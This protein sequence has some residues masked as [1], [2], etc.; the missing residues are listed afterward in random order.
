MAIMVISV[1]IPMTSCQPST[2]EAEGLDD[3]SL[4]DEAVDP[5][6][7]ERRRIAESGRQLLDPSAGGA[8]APGT[9]EQL[10]DAIDI[11][12]NYIVGISAQGPAPSMHVLNGWGII[13]PLRG[14]SFTVLST[15]VVNTFPEPGTDMAPG[16]VNGDSASLELELNIP[17]G[18]RRLSFYY[19]FLSSESPEFIGAGFN[20]TFTATLTEP[21]GT[22]HQLATASVDASEFHDA[23]ESNSRDTYFDIKSANTDGVNYLFNQTG[24]YD[25]GV[26]GFQRVDF[27]LPTTGNVTLHFEIHDE[28]DGILDSAVILDDLRLHAME[29]LSLNPI[30]DNAEPELINADGSLSDDSDELIAASHPVRGAAADGVTQVLL[31]TRVPGPGSM[32]YSLVDAVAPYNGENGGVSALNGDPG[33][34]AIVD[35][36]FDAA[37]GEHWAFAAYTVP[38]DF[39]RS[40]HEEDEGARRRNIEI[41]AQFIPDGATAP[42]IEDTQNLIIV[43]PPVILVGGVWTPT[44]PWYSYF[45]DE[46]R[47]DFYH[48]SDYNVDVNGDAIDDPYDSLAHITDYAGT[49][50]NATIQK[51]LLD[52][53]E[54]SIAASQ[55][56]IIAHGSGGLLVR[57]HMSQ[58]SYFENSHN[59][60]QGSIHKLIT[61]NTPHLGS[62]FANHVIRTRTTYDAIYP[63]KGIPADGGVFNELQEGSTFLDTMASVPTPSHAIVGTD[64]VGETRLPVNGLNQLTDYSGGIPWYSHIALNPPPPALPFA[65]LADLNLMLD[66]MFP[67]GQ[68][69]DLF[70]TIDSQSGGL[71]GTARTIVDSSYDAADGTTDSRGIHY[72]APGGANS[73]AAPNETKLDYETIFAQRLND[74]VNGDTFDQLPT[75]ASVLPVTETIPA[76]PGLP[77]ALAFVP[78]GLTI[79][80]PANNTPVEPG[81]EIEVIVEIGEGVVLE[82][83]FLFSEFGSAYMGQPVSPAAI[84]LPIREDAAGEINVRAVGFDAN[85][86]VYGSPGLDLGAVPMAPLDSLRLFPRTPYLFGEGSTLSATV[87][88]VYDDGVHRDVT[89][90]VTGTEYSSSNTSI[91]TVSPDGQVTATGPGK[92]TL[93]ARNGGVQDSVTVDVR[94]GMLAGFEMTTDWGLGYCASVRVTNNSTLPTTDWSV[95]MD[96]GDSTITETWNGVFS[97]MANTVEVGPEHE[98]QYAIP[99]GLTKGY[100]GFCATR[101]PSMQYLPTVVDVTANH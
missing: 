38:D 11:G 6:I 45:E 33:N 85:G 54:K 82:G 57:Q 12:Q 9:A 59:F 53:Q 73:N 25:A 61:V 75:P 40:D 24:G 76:D 23:S 101:G 71:S 14:D 80:S 56:D 72:W 39:V 17:V 51:A 18:M 13:E 37:S 86:D 47:F 49:R 52:Q 62:R 30:G 70:A 10:V 41:R 98:W 83:L 28:G 87:I 68:G 94:P 99:G 29:I 79:V 81:A 74:P 1:G 100:T 63:S 93:I 77:T 7:E 60:L 35:A 16:G 4:P 78:N 36:E 95:S 31:R 97:G 2:G 43:R 21:D 3:S 58:S 55:V 22:E 48:V 44:T 32:E 96:M 19:N 67:D 92:A 91:F 5:M 42:L 20:D 46:D 50:P 64:G 84:I 66:D 34:S 90:P 8:T 65:W 27:P 89:S 69:H 26:T 88:G 15:G